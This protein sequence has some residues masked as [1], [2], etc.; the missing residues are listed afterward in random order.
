MMT[1][2]NNADTLIKRQGAL[3]GEVQEIISQRP[4]WIVRNGI[5][6]F[7][8][9]ICGS[10][11][12]TNFISY[13]DII[14]T[15]A[16][17]TSLNAPK[18]IKS[19]I[20]GKLVKLLVTEN[21]TVKQGQVLGFMESGANHLEVIE[22]SGI[23]DSLQTVIN[24]NGAEKVPEYLYKKF[25]KLGEVQQPYQIF[26]QSFMLFRQYLSA[27][28]YLKKK[29]TLQADMGY[30]QKLHSNLLEQKNIEQ[31]D[32]VLADTTF[33]MQNRL[34]DE[35]VI[36]SLELRNERSKYLNKSMAIPQVNA[37]ITNNESSQHDKLKEILQLENDIAQQNGIFIQALN[38]L[39]AQLDEW[40]NKY[41]VIAANDGRVAFANF[42]QQ[43]QQLQSGQTILFIHAG[44]SSYYAEMVIPQY[45]FGKVALGQKVL[46][47]FP[48]YPFQEFGSVY[49]TIGFISEIPTDSGYLAKVLLPNGLVTNY[50]RQIR[51][52][53]GLTAQA[54]VI[55]KDLKLLQ[56]LMIQLT[57]AFEKK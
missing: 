48:S 52:R 30:M 7:L 35:K 23:I 45:N 40:K 19:K 13:P 24:N 14:V 43:N 56:R 6:M 5:M 31:A 1:T 29:V 18:E 26:M 42:V 55:T 37:T 10:L 16:K 46:L 47:K 33:K 53:D 3:S 12:V 21:E 22:L 25:E 44:N 38:T 49:G 20:T 9:I 27:G 2:E 28:F 17:L 11:G 54:D 15:S 36:S 41:L 57:T 39:K 32:L 51:F 34:R 50:H 4:N 8:V